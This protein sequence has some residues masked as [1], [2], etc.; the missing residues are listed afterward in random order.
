[1]KVGPPDRADYLGLQMLFGPIPACIIF[2]LRRDESDKVY[3]FTSLTHF[4]ISK[5]RG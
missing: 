1:M 2:I 3:N 4:F 5:M